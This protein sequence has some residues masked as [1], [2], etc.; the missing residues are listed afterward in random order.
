M[1]TTHT[2]R[3]SRPLPCFLKMAPQV[4]LSLRNL[5]KRD[6]SAFRKADTVG[7]V[8]ARSQAQPLTVHFLTAT[9]LY[10]VALAFAEQGCDGDAIAQLTQVI[11]RDPT[12]VQAYRERG[13]IY[14]RLGDNYRAAADLAKA[15][16]LESTLADE[17]A[18]NSD[19]S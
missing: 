19:H 8:S 6:R 7:S 12:Y 3:N 11:Q 14:G 5:R 13:K 2:D 16:A 17:P 1:L 9:E 10:E 4:A 18:I 15:T